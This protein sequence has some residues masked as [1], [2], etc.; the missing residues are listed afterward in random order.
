M[1][2]NKRM[3]EKE[4]MNIIRQPSLLELNN[5]NN[6]L[7]KEALIRFT[8]ELSKCKPSKKYSS[9]TFIHTSYYIFLY[10]LKKELDNNNYIRACSEIGSL[11]YRDDIFQGRVLYN[12][13]DVLKK[14]FRM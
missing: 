6:L 14:H 1:G 7:A 5:Q 3:D 9:P 2:V 8:K 11:A 12:L 10:L 13:S 4:I